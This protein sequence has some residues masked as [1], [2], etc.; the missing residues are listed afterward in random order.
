MTAA[1]LLVI[2]SSAAFAAATIAIRLCVRPLQRAALSGAREGCVRPDDLLFLRFAPVLI[3]SLL[4]SLLILPAFLLFE[5]RGR[6]ETAGLPIL[7][8]A[9]LGAAL[10]VTALWRAAQAL[11]ATRMLT[12]EWLGRARPLVRPGLRVPAFVVDVPYPLVAATGIIRQRLFV[13][14]CVLRV[15]GE[16]ELDAIF[17]HEAGHVAA[18]DNLR[19]L[20]LRACPDTLRGSGTERALERA[21]SAAAEEAADAFALDRGVD[22]V[23]L[24]AS[25]VAVARA[26]RPPSLAAIASAFLE[27]EDVERRVRRALGQPL[28]GQAPVWLPLLRP[29]AAILVLAVIAL[30]VIP[31]SLARIHHAVELGVGFLR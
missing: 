23:D 14:E 21:W 3:A 30:A 7:A 5:P 22:A 17:A 15:C 20:L 29:A 10:V 6:T 8:L 27:E 1:L 31:G 13:S 11:R 16:A 4:V 19:R 28:P 2:V 26:G 12:R 18:L 25:L 9:A 24:A